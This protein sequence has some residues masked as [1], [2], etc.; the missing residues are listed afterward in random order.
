VASREHRT[1]AQRV[2]RIAHIPG[3]GVGVEVTHASLPVL[4]RAA[5]QYDTRVHL[6]SL[7]W[8]AAHFE[9]TGAM[10]PAD[11]LDQ[12]RAYDAVLFGAFGDS[13]VPDD[14]GAWGLRLA[15][16]QGL[17]QFVS[18]RPA[19]SVEGLQGPLG[20]TTFDLVVV[21]ENSE[22]EFLGAGGRFHAGLESEGATE[23]AVFTRVGIARVADYAL[24]LAAGRRGRLT[25]V[26]KSNVQR[27]TMKLWDEVVRERAEAY[28]D[29]ELESMYVDA[30]AA[31][32]LLDPARF[33]VMLC[34]N[35]HGDILSDLAAGMMG[36]LGLAGSANLDPT[37]RA[38][39]MFEPVHGSAPDIAGRG[40]ANPAGTLRS[41]AFLLRHLELAEAG[42]VILRAVDDA[43]S[44]GVRTPDIGGTATTERMADAVLERIR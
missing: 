15:V 43:L 7:P 13:R 34:S 21:R 41:A 29:V 44:A 20:S 10:M 22:G 3:D 40:V 5:Q 37:G 30:A 24:G 26:T 6:T 2:L 31:A 39:S 9:E 12:L 25:C 32:L 16:C 18:Y 17:D 42:E 14:V 33:D 4:E 8:G 38:P 28:P 11:A 36:S 27:H 23:T 35:A 1:Q 19:W